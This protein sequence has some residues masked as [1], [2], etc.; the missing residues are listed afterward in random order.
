MRPRSLGP[1]NSRAIPIDPIVR[2]RVA[3]PHTSWYAA[4]WRPRRLCW[5]RP[6]AGW[7]WSVTCLAFVQR[8]LSI[9][10]TALVVV[11]VRE[12]LRRPAQPAR[13]RGPQ[14]NRD[15]RAAPRSVLLG[16]RPRPPLSRAVW[17]PQPPRLPARSLSM[18]P[19]ANRLPQ[20]RPARN[21]RR[22]K[23]PPRK[24]PPSAR[25]Q[26]ARGSWPGPMNSTGPPALLPIPPSGALTRGATAGETK[27]WS[28]TP[29]GPS[30]PS[31]TD[32]ETW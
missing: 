20:E 4:V 27:S 8:I 16:P 31:S 12:Q 3:C 23:L 28:P 19:P 1:L 30:T 32:V 18:Y 22:P 26:R 25:T 14:R 17:H 29:P 5:P 11:A 2:W 7:L 15:G 13:R 9:A 6:V 10:V 21:R 24:N